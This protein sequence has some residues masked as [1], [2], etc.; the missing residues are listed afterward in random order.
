MIQSCVTRFCEP[1]RS[2]TAR[3]LLESLSISRDTST[4]SDSPAEQ[5]L[6][7]MVFCIDV[8][9]ERIRR[10]LESQ[11]QDIETFG[12]AGFFA[13]PFEYL[14]AGVP[15]GTSHLPVLLKPQ[16]KL[17]EGLAE[18]ATPL[19]TEAIKSRQQIRSWRKLWKGFRSSAVGC[20]SFV[21]T[22][23]LY[24]G[25]KLLA[26]SFGYVTNSTRARFEGFRQRIARI[27]VRHF[28]A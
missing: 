25:W 28:A 5:K 23:G 27:W 3:Q 2:A 26:Q 17:Y 8:R 22:T 4:A 7:Q 21:E 24:Y 11:S 14:T 9:S 12:F 1:A 18:T 13:M 19:E 15:T 16:F 20:F 10:Q 6:A